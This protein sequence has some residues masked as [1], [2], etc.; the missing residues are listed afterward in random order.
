MAKG[1]P[2]EVLR[3]K[4]DRNA[5]I[6]AHNYQVGGVQD[7]ADFV[8]DS[9]DLSRRAAECDADV[10]VFC[11]VKFMAETAAI[12]SPDKKV[13]MPVVEAGCPM[14]EM[15]TVEQLKALQAEHPNAQTVAYVNS[16]A[17]IKAEVDICCTSSN[18]V[19]VVKSMDSEEII[20]VPDK[21]LGHYVST[22]VD[23]KIIPWEGYCPTHVA[24]LPE[25]VLRQKKAHPNAELMVHPEC[26]P[27][28]IEL[29]DHVFSTGGMVRYARESKVNELIVGTEVGIIHRLQKENPGKKFYPASEKA[30]CPNMKKTTLETVFWS[31]QEMK[32]EIMVPKEISNRAKG[33]IERMLE[34]V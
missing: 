16:N 13:L 30:V 34:I 12:L 22:Q 33:A 3:L 23:K 32:H 8:G 19:K 25:D 10:I 4:E 24:I 28:V 9:L 27:Q 6:L 17:D 15:I 21:Y 1:I 14:A 26:T 18:A 7:V 20:F 29:A 11:G 31:L 2:D 5:V